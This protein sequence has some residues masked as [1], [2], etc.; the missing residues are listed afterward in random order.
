MTQ[1]DRIETN[2]P[3]SQMTADSRDGQTH[4][5]IGLR[6]RFIENFVR[7]QTFC[8]FSSAHI[9]AICGLDHEQEEDSDECRPPDHNDQLCSIP[10]ED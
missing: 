6:L 5:I 7:D 3:M 10:A 8:V 4:P 9:C 1:F 2:P